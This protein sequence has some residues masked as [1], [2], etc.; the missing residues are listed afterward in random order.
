MVPDDEILYTLSFLPFAPFA[1]CSHNLTLPP[2]PPTMPQGGGGVCWSL[3]KSISVGRRLDLFHSSSL[4]S[5]S[6]LP[7]F[8][9]TT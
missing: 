7:R 2:L 9:S 1:S 4:P 3:Q 5:A 6:T 8:V